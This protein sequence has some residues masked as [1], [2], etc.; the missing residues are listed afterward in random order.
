MLFGNDYDSYR[1]QALI[2]I[3]DLAPRPMSNAQ[4][5]QFTTP[6]LVTITSNM[7]GS[8]LKDFSVNHQPETPGKYN[9][10]MQH[11]FEANCPLLNYLYPV[12]GVMAVI[13]ATVGLL[14]AALIYK[15]Y[16][17][18]Q[19]SIQKWLFVIPVAKCVF[20]G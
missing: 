15:C 10:Q 17:V 5:Q 16:H 2:M 1:V 9:F 13:M 18:Q 20:Y 7:H 8:P 11:Y 4:A 14:W 12:L 6:Q 19:H 3:S